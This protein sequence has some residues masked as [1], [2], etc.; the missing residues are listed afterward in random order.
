MIETAKPDL[1]TVRPGEGRNGFDIVGAAGLVGRVMN[2]DVADRIAAA[3]NATV[4][5]MEG[6][7]VRAIWLAEANYE[8]WR[9]ATGR[10]VGRSKTH[11]PV[12]GSN[13]RPAMRHSALGRS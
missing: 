1:W 13:M 4:Y 3:H 11:D 5:Q 9:A 12:T 2:G 6:D 10:G 7:L 8:A